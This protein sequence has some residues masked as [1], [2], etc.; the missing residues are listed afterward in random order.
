MK[1]I[2]TL[3]GFIGLVAGLTL[4]HPL[5]TEGIAM[6]SAGSPTRG[7]TSSVLASSED[8]YVVPAIASGDYDEGT[9]RDC[10]G[11]RHEHTH[12]NN[13]S[14]SGTYDYYDVIH[15]TAIT[16]EDD[17]WDYVDTTNLLCTNGDDTYVDCGFDK[18]TVRD[19]EVLWSTTGGEWD[20]VTVTYY[21]SLGWISGHP[22]GIVWE[23]GT[24]HPGDITYLPW[25]KEGHQKTEGVSWSA[26]TDYTADHTVTTTSWTKEEF[27]YIRDTADHSDLD[28]YTHLY[29]DEVSGHED[30]VDPD[31]DYLY[32]YGLNATVV[33]NFIA[34]EAPAITCDSLELTKADGT[35]VDV[36]DLF[37]D[38]NLKVTATGTDG[39][40]E[41]DITADST[42]QYYVNQYGSANTAGDASGTLKYGSFGLSSGKHPNTTDSTVTFNGVEP[43]DSVY[44][45][46]SDYEGAAYPS[47]YDRIEFPYCAD[48]SITDPTGLFG[49]G[50]LGVISEASFDTNITVEATASS[51]EAWPFNITYDSTDDTATYDGENDPYN[52][53]DY[54]VD[55]Y[56][57]E[58]SATVTVSADDDVANLCRDSFNY[59]LVPPIELNTC[60]DLSF[61]TTDP[62][63]A[64]DM[65]A[66]NVEISWTSTMTDGTPTPPPYVCMS[67]N[68]PSGTFRDP[69]G[70]T[71]TGSITTSL[72]TVY[73]TGE[74]GDIIT[75][76]SS[77]YPACTD[78]LTSETTTT[79][80]SCN[81][82]A[83]SEP[84]I[85][86]DGGITKTTIDLTDDADLALLY[87]NSTVCYD[88]SITVSDAAFS[89][90]LQAAGYTDST[91]SA[92]SGNLSLTVNEM[93]L[94][95][96]TNP[97]VGNPATVAINGNSS[98]TGTL[99]WENYEP[100]NYL[101]LQVLG[102]PLACYED[103]QLPSYTPGSYA[104]TDL[105][106]SPDTVTIAA[107]SS[108]AGPVTLTVTV[109][110]SDAA[111]S[112]NLLVTH[113][114]NGTLYYP[115]GT[116]STEGDGHLEVPV[117]GL[118]TTLT[119]TYV[120]G[121][122]G[123][124]VTAVIE[125]EVGACTDNL[126]MTQ[127]TGGGGGGLGPKRQQLPNTTGNNY[128]VF[129]SEG[130]NMF[131]GNED[132]DMLHQF[133]VE[134][135]D[136]GYYDDE[137]MMEGGNGEEY[138]QAG[139]MDENG[140]YKPS[141]ALERMLQNVEVDDE[142]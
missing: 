2:P 105:E 114:G 32:W 95:T 69:A 101:D 11:A 72:T 27:Y 63:S 58:E 35:A 93:P 133:E 50:Y 10:E 22:R 77:L 55:H 4:T 125:G 59:T 70:I 29:T 76:R 14:S 103:S 85:T 66:G 136:G 20:G 82:V 54:T 142:I 49:S 129:I 30:E 44:V 80:Y 61:L 109:T 51:G 92:Y 84:Y 113:T 99:C 36:N 112:G 5:Y 107:G 138:M 140:V 31:G 24:D 17:F 71:G 122:A 53:D 12:I 91:R 111:W 46:V 117:S 75:C 134:Q 119:F 88:Y 52:T 106:L 86:T 26:L 38:V 23:Y 28:N 139:S 25:E 37:S 21:D 126:T 15:A 100:G 34:C 45:Y 104:C 62:I 89:D 83:L 73:Y 130:A 127:E 98:Y 132:E 118:S 116:T 108:T 42:F 43:G 97:N 96:G 40:T 120:D 78:I 135:Q 1:K 102:A 81:D 39:T 18:D 74:A 131:P 79:S 57:S 67:I 128:P 9:H 13:T 123:D 141:A 47:C 16:L 124:T 137:M 7:E 48:L 110:G 115:D 68:N 8:N 64:E 90:T 33:S 65:A 60:E 3:F 121:M 19:G 56:L 6:P 94:V 41:S 87:A